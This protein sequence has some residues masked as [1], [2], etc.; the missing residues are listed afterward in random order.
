MSRAGLRILGM[1][2]Q[3]K[4]CWQGICLVVGYGMGTIMDNIYK[5]VSSSKHV[6][7]NIEEQYDLVGEYLHISYCK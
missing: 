6:S 2:G 1:L 4:M 5:M 7:F 3:H